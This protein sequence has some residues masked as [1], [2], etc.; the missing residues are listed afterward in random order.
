[1]LNSVPETPDLDL[2]CLSYNLCRENLFYKIDQ[3][4]Y[5]VDRDK[6][7]KCYGITLTTLRFYNTI[8]PSKKMI[9]RVYND[10]LLLCE[11]KILLG[12]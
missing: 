6:L 8:C 9:D 4:L 1:M 10:I 11:G 7:C 3:W 2:K 5:L 12:C